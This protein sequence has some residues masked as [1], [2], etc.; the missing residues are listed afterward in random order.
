MPILNK[1]NLHVDVIHAGEYGNAAKLIRK[2]AAQNLALNDVLHIARIPAHT[3]LIDLTLFH[4][5]AGGTSTVKVGYVP[6]DAA[7]GA[8]DDAFFIASTSTVAA[9]RKRADTVKGPIKL[10]Y[11]VDIVITAT[12]AFAA[13][14]DLTVVLDYE[15]RGK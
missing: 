5:A 4:G 3:D 7:N 13:A 14:A 15:W 11:A 12:V 2:Q 1:E 10:A 9:G 8:G 6:V